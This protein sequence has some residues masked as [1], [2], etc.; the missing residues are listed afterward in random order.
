MAR[1]LLRI[2]EKK[3]ETKPAPKRT[4][5]KQSAPPTLQPPALTRKKKTSPKKK[6]EPPPPPPE[7]PKK[8]SV[9]RFRTVVQ[10]KVASV[11]A[12]RRGIKKRQEVPVIRVV[13]NEAT[14]AGA[15]ILKAGDWE[16]RGLSVTFSGL[17]S[18]VPDLRRICLPHGGGSSFD[19][20]RSASDEVLPGS[21]TDGSMSPPE[22]FLCALHAA[23]PGRS[24]LSIDGASLE[25]LM[26]YRDILMQRI[27]HS[28]LELGEVNRLIDEENGRRREA[29]RP[30]HPPAQPL[31]ADQIRM[32]ASK[33]YSFPFLCDRG[34][35]VSSEAVPE[36]EYSWD[37]LLGSD[38]DLVSLLNAQETSFVQDG[39]ML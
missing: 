4:L 30:P 14:Q 34:A 28:L 2:A 8:H 38:F 3:R 21:R 26:E 32:L 35:P 37:S 29:R 36:D 20:A 23:F 12:F 9:E 7:P 10:T 27:A 22:D 1:L 39:E 15:G 16:P 13:T 19:S 17:G 24:G 25:H 6:A 33:S 18:S 31:S 5:A 11:N